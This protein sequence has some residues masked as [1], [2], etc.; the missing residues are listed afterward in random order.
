M[1]TF[2]PGREDKLRRH[3]YRKTV[4]NM[5]K[6]NNENDQDNGDTFLFY[7]EARADGLRRRVSSAYKLEEEYAGR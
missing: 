7:A 2:D 3:V 5:E 6:D 1:E 4:N